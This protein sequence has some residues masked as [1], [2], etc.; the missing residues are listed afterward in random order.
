MNSIK[1]K[2]VGEIV[3]DD[4]RAATIFESFGIDF[5]CKGNKT[6]DEVCESKGIKKNLLLNHLE[7]KLGPV[8][9][10]TVDYKSWSIDKLADHI[11]GKHHKYVEERTPVLQQ[12]LNKICMV[13]GR[14]H[15]ELLQIKE[16]FERSA[17]D[18]AAHMKKE[19]LI[20]FPAVRK[21]AAAHV[22]GSMQPMHFGTVK[23]P[24]HRMMHEHEVEGDIFRKIAELSNN[25]TPPSDACTTYKVA[26]I[27]LKEFESDLH[28]HI[29]LENNILFPKSVEMEKTVILE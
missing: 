11:E 6:I 2:T 13:H 28:L 3:A 23:N 19:E 7:K 25:Y 5:C 4:Y 8:S 20:L 24:I 10:E 26:F 22:S 9:N 29:H 15:P 16:L 27:M 17:C 1:E 12:Y 18:L 14:Q 21:M